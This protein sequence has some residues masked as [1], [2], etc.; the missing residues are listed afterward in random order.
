MRALGT[1]SGQKWSQVRPQGSP[2]GSSWITFRTKKRPKCTPEIQIR[3][4][5]EYFRMH[6]IQIGRDFHLSQS[7]L[8]VL[9]ASQPAS[10]IAS[11]QPTSQPASQPASSQPASQPA[12]H[13]QTET[14]NQ[15]PGTRRDEGGRRQRAKPLGYAAPG[16]WPVVGVVS[17]PP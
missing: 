9:S 12:N 6:F 1:P 10:Q 2:Q 15:Q 4:I 11:S 16:I 7:V 17:T 14:S 13:Q 5:F 3:L 8:N